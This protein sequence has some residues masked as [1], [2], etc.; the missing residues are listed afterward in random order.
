MTATLTLLFFIFIG[1]MK[2][3]QRLDTEFFYN[4]NC[5]IEK[6]DPLHS[7]PESKT[8][9]LLVQS[10]STIG[11][12]LDSQRNITRFILHRM[13]SK[14]SLSE[15]KMHR[16]WLI[17]CRSTIS[18]LTIIGG[19]K[20]IGILISGVFSTALIHTSMIWIRR[21]AK[22]KKFFKN[23]PRM[24]APK[25][26]LVYGSPKVR[27]LRGSNRTIRTKAYAIETLRQD[28]DDMARILKQAYKDN[29]T[30]VLF[31]MRSRHPE[32][33]EKMIRTQTQLG[34][35]LCYHLEL[36]GPDVM[37]YISEI[38]L[39]I[40]GVQAILPCK[41]VNDNGKYKI[42][43]NKNRSVQHR[44]WKP[45]FPPNSGLQTSQVPH[46][47]GGITKRLQLNNCKDLPISIPL[48]G[49]Q[50][51]QHCNNDPIF[52]EIKKHPKQQNG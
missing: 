34:W 49:K 41:L 2:S 18:M 32:A 30:F 25:F 29:G 33:F 22:S 36:V 47:K 23:A 3:K 38:I 13:Q 12:S 20:L 51:I 27:T 40:D 28:R 50:L 37:H 7:M 8:H 39:M 52:K 11:R 16:T 15:I 6:L 46:Q 48:K 43:V 24:K 19:A 5:K 9:H 17:L 31:R 4:N 35:Q 21:H 44:I 45:M 26:W 42:M 1:C 10:S 14:H